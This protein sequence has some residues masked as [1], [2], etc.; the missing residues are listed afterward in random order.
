MV[1]DRVTKKERELKRA[2]ALTYDAERDNAPRVTAKGSGPIA[3]RII[4][5]AA[6]HGIP[7][8]NDPALVQVLSKLDIGDTIPV[9]LYQAVA[10]V[11]AFVY[12]LN[13]ERRRA[14]SSP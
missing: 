6:K 13:E 2:A 3:E 4:E 9:E 1:G 14:S 5:L 8:R 12:R 10:E 11:L 7:V